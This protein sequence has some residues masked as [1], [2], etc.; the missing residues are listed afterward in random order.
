M[1]DVIAEFIGALE[2]QGVAHQTSRAYKADLE[3][4]AA[5]YQGANGEAMTA[6][7]IT[8]TDMREYRSY[9]QTVAGAAPSTIN[10]AEQ[11]P[12]GRAPTLRPLGDRRRAD[13]GRSDSPRQGGEDGA[14]GAEVAG[15]RAWP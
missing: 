11:T 13:L 15:P 1:S 5:W 7:G 2:N 4:F 6:Q 14:D 10:R 3:G 9:L 12:A 8:P